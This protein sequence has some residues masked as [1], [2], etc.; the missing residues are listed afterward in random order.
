MN[1]KMA[2]VLAS[3]QLQFSKEAL[4]SLYLQTAERLH[5]TNHFSEAAEIYL[6]YCSDVDKAIES[7]LSACSWTN[8][9]RIASLHEKHDSIPRVKSS[10]LEA[11]ETIQSSLSEKRDSFKKLFA[12]LKVIQSNKQMLPLFVGQTGN[13]E[14]DEANS[15]FSE[16]TASFS[17]SSHSQYSSRYSARTSQTGHSTISLKKERKKKKPKKKLSGRE[18]NP[19]EEEYIITTMSSHFNAVNR[20]YYDEVHELLKALL[21]LGYH[22]EAK[23]IQF[24][25]QEYIDTINQATETFF[26]S[27]KDVFESGN[28]PSSTANFT[29]VHDR[30]CLV[31]PDNG[32][33][34]KQLEPTPS[35]K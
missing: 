31:V 1:W 24:L 2:F 14:R 5:S 16:S 30:N 21:H 20:K 9:L 19:Y 15:D 29:L 18:G 4:Q 10:V 28:Q 27:Q 25:L 6:E 7:F 32:W 35:S 11:S 33:K 22:S 26:I 13:L 23:K 17:T 34:L 12:R 3:N 8:A